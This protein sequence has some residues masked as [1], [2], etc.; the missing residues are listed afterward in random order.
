MGGKV[1]SEL[2]KNYALFREAVDN[3]EKFLDR[4]KK[5]NIFITFLEYKE[6]KFIEILLINTEKFYEESHR[7][8]EEE[9]DKAIKSFHYAHKAIEK[10]EEQ[11]NISTESTLVVTEVGE[12]VLRYDAEWGYKMKE[13]AQNYNVRSVVSTAIAFDKN[14]IGL[15][16]FFY[17][18]TLYEEEDALWRM[19]VISGCEFVAH[20]L[21]RS[22]VQADLFLGTVKALSS[23]IDAK[24]KWTDGHSK[25][26]TDLAL[27]IGQKMNLSVNELKTLKLASLL[28]DIGKI[29]VRDCILDNDEKLEE[30]DWEKLKKHPKTGEEILSSIK[31]LED[32]IPIIK[33][34]HE[35]FNGKG[36]P[37]RLKGDQIPFIARILMIADSI[38]AMANKR[39]YKE[40]IKNQDEI[41]K[42]LDDCSGTHFDPKV[43]AAVLKLIEEKNLELR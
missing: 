10:A 18:K 27:Q 24:S 12:D 15:I 21:I 36:Y 35:K 40:Q 39:P 14:P 1:V 5:N 34:H 29:G 3:V 33:G 2:E 26:V 9:G 38:D 43:V 32:A 25:R 23:A 6:G 17:N 37:D 13:I 41:I 16:N 11:I 19:Q 31:Q 4:F 20:L 7:L 30:E 42:E 28:H 22:M 8:Q